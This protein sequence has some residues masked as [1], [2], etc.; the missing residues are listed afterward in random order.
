MKALTFSK[1]YNKLMKNYLQLLKNNNPKVNLLKKNK[2]RNCL[3]LRNLLLNNQHQKEDLKVLTNN[4]K[5]FQVRGK[6]LLKNL[7]LL[8]K[9]NLIIII[10][11]SINIIIR[12]LKV[13]LKIQKKKI[14]LLNKSM[15]LLRSLFLSLSLLRNLRPKK[16]STIKKK[17]WL[18]F[19]RENQVFTSKLVLPKVE[20]ILNLNNNHNKFILKSHKGHKLDMNH[21]R[22]QNPSKN[23]LQ[24]NLNHHKKMIKF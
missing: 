14:N 24:R 11:N 15:S 12:N 13:N 18:N 21:Q 2:L 1:L 17:L 19:N 23:I 20:S 16:I 5:R 6:N 7:I 22:K 4:N 3:L 8:S 9:K 10:K